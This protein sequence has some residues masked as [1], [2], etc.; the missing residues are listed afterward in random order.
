[1]LQHA[2]A[3]LENEHSSFVRLSQLS[4]ELV[5]RLEKGNGAAANDV[6]RRLDT[7]TQRWDNLVA[8]IEE[9]S[10]IV[11]MPFY[12]QEREPGQLGPAPQ[13]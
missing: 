12:L 6:R 2:E 13:L 8:R 4:C 9:H 3:A 5:A 11:S 10:R 1:M 7:V